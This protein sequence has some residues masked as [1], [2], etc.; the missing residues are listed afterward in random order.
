MHSGENTTSRMI[1]SIKAVDSSLEAGAFELEG[2]L[3]KSHVDTVVREGAGE[4]GEKSGW[5]GNGTFFLYFSTNPATNGHFQ[6][7]GG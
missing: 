4:L 6:V 1:I 3:G 2:M 5:D 7:G